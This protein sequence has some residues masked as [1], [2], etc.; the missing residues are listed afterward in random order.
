MPAS[1]VCE[2]RRLLQSWDGVFGALG[3]CAD[4][5]AVVQSVKQDWHLAKRQ[6]G[7]P[8]L[9]SST[10]VSSILTLDNCVSCFNG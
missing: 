9:G 1:T 2:P 7:H 8:N 3:G 10:A 6:A 5:I 4:G